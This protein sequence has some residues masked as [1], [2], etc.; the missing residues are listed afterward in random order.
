[1]RPGSEQVEHLGD[2]RR[3]RVLV[4]DRHPHPA[5]P[6]VGEQLA[7]AAGVLAADRR[8]A[9]ARFDGPRRQ[10]AEVADRGADEDQRTGPDGRQPAACCS[11]ASSWR[12]SVGADLDDVAEPQAPALERPCLRLDHGVR[13]EDWRSHPVPWDAH[14]LDHDAGVVQ[15]GDVDREAHP[16][17][18]DPVAS[19]DDERSLEP[20]ASDQALALVPM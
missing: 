12:S 15:V 1:M 19:R 17:R 5:D 6:G 4:G 16:D 11:S 7:G 10:I 8:G 13:L 9:C 18:V 20:V 14:D 2:P 3:L